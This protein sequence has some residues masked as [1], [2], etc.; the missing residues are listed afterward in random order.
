[1]FSSDGELK[2]FGVNMKVFAGLN[3]L[4]ADLERV[5]RE[6]DG[7]RENFGGEMDSKIFHYLNFFG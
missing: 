7:E 3:V 2:G 6:G 4:E 5:R 1:M